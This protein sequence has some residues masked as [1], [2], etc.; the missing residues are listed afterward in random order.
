MI[1]LVAVLVPVAYWVL[2]FPVYR[3]RV[4]L[5]VKLGKEALSAI[6]S[7]NNEAYNILFQQRP[8][9]INNELEILRKGRYSDEL[10]PRVRATIDSCYAARRLGPL[11]KV[12]LGARTLVRGTKELVKAPF[13]GLGLTRPATPEETLLAQLAKALHAEIVEETDIIEVR[14]DWDD[15]VIAALV[16]NQIVDE[17]LALHVRVHESERSSGFYELQ[18]LMYEDSL[19]RAEQ[20]LEGFTTTRNIANIELQKDILLR[21][22]SDLERRLTDVVTAHASARSKALRVREVHR[23]SKGWITTPKVES[24]DLSAFHELDDKYFGLLAERQQYLPN[25][26]EVERIDRDITR[27]RDQKAEGVLNILDSELN[28]LDKERTA[29]EGTLASKRAEFSRL[30]QETVR[31]ADHERERDVLQNSYLIYRRKAEQLRMS[32]AMDASQITSVRVV[33]RAE[34]PERPAYPRM[35]RVLPVAVLAGMFLALLYALVAQAVDHTFKRE[36]DVATHLD[37]PLLMSIPVL[38]HTR[39]TG[40]R[41]KA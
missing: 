4:H 24:S 7:Y 31:L 18:A 36:D 15:P 10:L 16:L 2:T 22:I 23:K 33:A 35:G 1:L 32:D 6:S 41:S 34:P 17:Y 20:S 30:N 21:D 5:L 12:R 28:A 14:F 11:G 29:L 27:L 3:A 19:R 9:N 38:G 13:Y 37:A 8:Q 25:P 26:S 40:P 39:I